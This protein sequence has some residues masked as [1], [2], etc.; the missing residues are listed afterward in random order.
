MGRLPKDLRYQI[1][2]GDSFVCRFC[3]IGGRYSDIILEVHHI[4]WRRHGG[5]DEPFNLMTVC[6]HC[7]D[8]IH[9]GRW[10]GRPRTFTE[11][12]KNQGRE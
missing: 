5:S 7:H 10:T 12:K 6:V 8:V 2:E 4:K 1:L 3:G 9:Y 11:A